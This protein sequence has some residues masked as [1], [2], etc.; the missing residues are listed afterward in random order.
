MPAKIAVK[1]RQ[2]GLHPVQASFNRAKP[3]IVSVEPRI[4]QK[5]PHQNQ[6]RRDADT[7]GQLQVRHARNYTALRLKN[8]AGAV[9]FEPASPV[10]ETGSLT[11]ELTPL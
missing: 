10:L 6:Q 1:L 8:L 11:V 4:V 7:Q 2:V 3:S 9:G 5:D